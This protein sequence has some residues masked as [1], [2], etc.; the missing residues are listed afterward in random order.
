[1]GSP[2]KRLA[3]LLMLAGLMIAACS[4]AR[5][6]DVAHSPEIA[7]VTP[8]QAER[9]NQVAD[10]WVASGKA[11][12]VA[13][14]VS[15][16]G[17]VV[18]ARGFGR[19]NLGSAAPVT[20]ATAFRIGSVSKQ[21]TAAAIM[22]LVQADKVSLD[23]TVSVYFPNFPRGDEVTVRQL[24]THTSG[25]RNYTEFGMNPWAVV[26]M[27]RDHTTDAWTRYIAGQKPLYDF[28]PGSA[29][30]YS[31]SGFFLL[32]AIV[33]KVS[34]EPLSIYLRD[35]IFSPLGMSQTAIDGNSDIGPGRARGYDHAWL[36][37][38][39]FRRPM[40]V[41]MTVPGGAGALR[42]SAD[43]LTRWLNGLYGGKVVDPSLLDQ[44]ITPARLTDG[45]L[46]SLNRINVDP[47][48]PSG[49][50]GF[51]TQIGQLDGHRELGHDGDIPGF[52]ATLHVYPDDDQLTVVV[53]ANTPDGAEN[54]EK[55][56]A[57]IMLG[58][59]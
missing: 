33:E 2:S 14:E 54:L 31:N 18:F 16:G 34:G 51:G 24:L 49:D 23:D 41:S 5:P 57:R 29:W 15:R 35:N 56:V 47:A 32:G 22:Q 9:I 27:M 38:R 26:Q 19:A 44:M 3:A 10:A 21:F 48:E 13:V 1:M 7:L 46:A 59:S 58:D 17:Q 11:V 4:P 36:P 43:D 6:T 55:Q 25:I 37:G 52:N 50:Y 12:G 42:S 8:V 39:G 40:Y 20:T 30:H 53:V 28:A 45:R